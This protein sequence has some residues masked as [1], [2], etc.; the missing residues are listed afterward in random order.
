MS[1][2]DP[3]G[4]RRKLSWDRINRAFQSSIEMLEKAGDREAAV[5]LAQLKLEFN[6]A[7]SNAK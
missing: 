5:V 4:S 2:P 3:T 7:L 1:D 6:R